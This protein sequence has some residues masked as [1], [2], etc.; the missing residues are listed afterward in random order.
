MITGF[1]LIVFLLSLFMLGRVLF[2]NKKVDSMILTAVILLM[3]NCLGRYMLATAE[4][5]SMA[6][7]ANKIIYLGACFLP[8]MTVIILARLCEIK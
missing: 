5:L 7:T 3:M 2:V 6:L 4:C 8:L 1:Y